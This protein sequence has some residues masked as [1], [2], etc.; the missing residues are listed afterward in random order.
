[1]IMISHVFIIIAYIVKKNRIPQKYGGFNIT[2]LDWVTGYEPIF[3]VLV[4]P[5]LKDLNSAWGLSLPVV[6]ESLG[7]CTGVETRSCAV[8]KLLL[9]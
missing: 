2:D 5:G 3:T 1:M 7:G 4:G 6:G 8:A 9:T